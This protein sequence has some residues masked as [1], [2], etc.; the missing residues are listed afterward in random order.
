MLLHG[1][2]IALL[3]WVV[4]RGD[5]GSVRVGRWTICR[6]VAD[7]SNGWVGSDGSL[8]EHGQA[9][10]RVGSGQNS[11]DLVE[12]WQIWPKTGCEWRDL[13]GSWQD[14]VGSRWDPT[15]KIFKQSRSAGLLKS[16]LDVRTRQLTCQNWVWYL[17]NRCRPV[18]R[19]G[20]DSFW[21]GS[22]RIAGRS[23]QRVILDRPSCDIW[24]WIRR[25]SRK[26]IERNVEVIRTHM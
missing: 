8:L 7:Q 15:K 22:V 23:S 3:F 25:E 18:T 17:E 11:S 5:H 14:L 20:K 4:I 26:I 24:K 12:I 6:L 1:S 2:Q 16:S 21:I 13:V 10:I 9:S 19:V